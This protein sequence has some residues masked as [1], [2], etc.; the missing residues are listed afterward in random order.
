MAKQQEIKL[1]LLLKTAVYA[2]LQAIWPATPIDHSS[3]MD[4]S[5]KV[6]HDV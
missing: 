2:K 3:L 4:R 6:G 1:K 5:F